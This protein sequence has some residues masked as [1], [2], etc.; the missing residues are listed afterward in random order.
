MESTYTLFL[1]TLK[2]NKDNPKLLELMSE[3]S[4]ELSRKKI[5]KL[6]D[7]RH[8]QN[9]LGELFELYTKALHDEGL[10]TPRALHSIIDGLLKAASHD[11]ETFLYKTIY[12]KEQLEKSILTQKAHIRSTILHT[13][14]VLEAHTKHLHEESREAALIAL[15]DAKLRGI[16]M[17]G[18]L[19]ETAQEAFITT[20]EKGSDVEDTI[21][22][23]AKNLCFHTINEGSLNRTRILDISR[24]LI[25]SSIEIAN[26]DLGHAK[27]ILQGCVY[28]VR[29]GIAK[30]IDKFRND[31]KYA[32]TEDIEGLEESELSLLRKELLKIDELFVE[33]L[34]A[35]CAQSEGISEE[36]LRKI[37]VDLTSSVAKIRRAAQE[38]KEVI[39]ERIEKLKTDAYELEKTLKGRAEKKIEEFKKDAL[40]LEKIA[41]SKIESL[42]Q[43]DFETE[44]AKHMASE[45]KKLGFRAWEVA[46]SM[47]DGAIK[48]AKE[49][50]KKEDK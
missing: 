36:I 3:L 38:A 4:F 20:L 29:D 27:D 47:V 43:F 15:S 45:A 25:E 21:Y 14:L 35:L 37:V 2:E 9:R 8:I 32:A 42:K 11:K 17:L 24:T 33:Q 46:K 48:N 30:S 1:A 31:L 13:F 26:E 10:K 22:E 34:E 28:G 44:K 18:I 6:K 50:I 12:E 16:E 39:T 19:K 5:Q 23:I 7:E 40:E 49:A 41:S